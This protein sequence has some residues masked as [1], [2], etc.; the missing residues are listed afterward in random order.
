MLKTI[1][2]LNSALLTA[3]QI[4]KEF[5]PPYEISSIIKKAVKQLR[6]ELHKK[7]GGN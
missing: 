7:K 3:K 1:K 4:E 5:S 2:L 6:K